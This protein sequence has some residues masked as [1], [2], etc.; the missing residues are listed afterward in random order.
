MC[1]WNVSAPSPPA[2]GCQNADT[3]RAWKRLCRK[4]PSVGS[5]SMD[6]DCCSEAHARADPFLLPVIRPQDRR[7]LRVTAIQ[8]DKFGAQTK[9]TPG[10]Q[11][12]ANFIAISALILQ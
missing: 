11:S 8:A 5:F 9:D 1:M 6:T 7:L 3:L 2:F 10:I 4:R 12:I